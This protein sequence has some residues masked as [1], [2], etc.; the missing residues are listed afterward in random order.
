MLLAHSHAHD[1]STHSECDLSF[2]VHS[3]ESAASLALAALPMLALIVSCVVIL[4]GAEDSIKRT[5]QISDTV[6]V[7]VFALPLLS[8]AVYGI[9]LLMKR[10]GLGEVSK[11]DQR[12]R[13]IDEEAAIKAKAST[14]L[15]S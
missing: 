14:G 12:Q 5:V 8:L 15:S 1:P 11:E 9:Q 6:M 13:D 4:V 10:S 7:S 2:R 3:M